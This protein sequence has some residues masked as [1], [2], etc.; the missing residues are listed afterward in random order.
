[1]RQRIRSLLLADSSG[2]SSGGDVGSGGD[3]CGGGVDGVDAD[4]DIAVTLAN[5]ALMLACMDPQPTPT[6]TS[7]P[8]PLFFSSGSDDHTA[9][10]DS[11]IS[12]K[13]EGRKDGRVDRVESGTASGGGAGPD[14]GGSEGGGRGGGF[15]S[16]R[17]MENFEEP[18][19]TSP[20][21]LLRHRHQ[22]QHERDEQ[23]LLDGREASLL[24]GYLCAVAS[25]AEEIKKSAEAA[26]VAAAAPA[27][28]SLS[29]TVRSGRNKEGTRP[30]EIEVRCEAGIR[31]AFLCLCVSEAHVRGGEGGR[32]S[33][34]ATHRSQARSFARR[35][36]FPTGELVAR[37]TVYIP[38]AA[39]IFFHTLTALSFC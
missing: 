20:T 14:P 24:M 31:L 10:E 33:V 9:G 17:T 23:A 35:F 19:S 39:R 15:G 4:I 38:S 32:R 37:T 21:Q 30:R 6:P 36:R 5:G 26:A 28:S 13:E 2:S 7:D 12:V 22:H 3:G 18:G 34:Q 27:E 29:A 25:T 11:S 8:A 16:P 1:M